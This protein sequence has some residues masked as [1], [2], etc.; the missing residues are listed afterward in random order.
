MKYDSRCILDNFSEY[1]K[2]ASVKENLKKETAKNLNIS[3]LNIIFV[4]GIQFKYHWSFFFIQGPF[5]QAVG[6]KVK[7]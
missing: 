1:L 7:L 5:G 4:L 6:V 3:Y 2:S